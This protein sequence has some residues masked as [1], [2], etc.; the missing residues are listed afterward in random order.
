M[1][2]INIVKMVLIAMKIKVKFLTATTQNDTWIRVRLMWCYFSQARPTTVPSFVYC[3]CIRLLVKNIRQT[4]SNSLMHYDRNLSIYL[5][6][7]VCIMISNPE[8]DHQ[9]TQVRIYQICQ[10][11]QTETCVAWY[12]WPDISFLKLIITR[13]W[14]LNV[15]RPYMSALYRITRA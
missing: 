1:L 12:F 6:G 9:T 10:Q 11:T 8:P 7:Y 15:L 3:Y 14:W 5:L 4:Y 2:N 13:D